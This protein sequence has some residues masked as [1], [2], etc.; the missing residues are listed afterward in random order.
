MEHH[1]A[2]MNVYDKQLYEYLKKIYGVQ[3]GG[4]GFGS[5]SWSISRR[6][7]GGG[8]NEIGND[9]PSSL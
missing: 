5:N 2:K 3:G 8:I 7:Y 6:R 9:T 1:L 4:S